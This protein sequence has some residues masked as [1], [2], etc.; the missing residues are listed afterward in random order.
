MNIFC[1]SIPNIL[2]VVLFWHILNIE[3][4][5][6]KVYMTLNFLSKKPAAFVV[7]IRKIR[8]RP[9]ILFSSAE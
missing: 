8:R 6:Q 9:I 2:V 1:L 4:T 7:I 3:R 5:S